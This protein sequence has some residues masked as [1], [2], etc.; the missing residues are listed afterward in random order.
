MSLPTNASGYDYL[1]DSSVSNY[2]VCLPVTNIP[3]NNEHVAIIP[4]IKDGLFRDPGLS[5]AVED[6][7]VLALAVPVNDS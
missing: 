2:M 4:K 1:S 7:Q 5:F 6:V 3:A